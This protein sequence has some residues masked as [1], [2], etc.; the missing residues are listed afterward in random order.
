VAERRARVKSFRVPGA[1]YAR[2]PVQLSELELVGQWLVV[3]EEQ[4][5]P[6]R[7]SGL[8]VVRQGT[9]HGV[10]G[11]VIL[12]GAEAELEG[13]S[14]GDRIIYE[15]WAGGRWALK[16]EDGEDVRVLVMSIDKVLAL[17]SK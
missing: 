13:L 5:E 15:E 9:A 16:G 11:E 8:V 2:Q 6:E 17:V 3:R 14:A 4:P 1:G 10:L 7:P 12:A